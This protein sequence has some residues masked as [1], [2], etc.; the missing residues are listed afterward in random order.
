MTIYANFF[1][2]YPNFARFKIAEGK[3][4]LNVVVTVAGLELS[5]FL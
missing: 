4:Y 5:V 2:K 1:R 3:E